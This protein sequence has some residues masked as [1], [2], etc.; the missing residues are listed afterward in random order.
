MKTETRLQQ[1]GQGRFSGV[2]KN[3]S[4]D[5]Y[6]SKDWLSQEWEN[7]WSKTWQIGAH[8]SDLKSPGDFVVLDL[9]PESILIALPETGPIRAFYNVC[10]H[11][12]VRLVEA[13]YGNTE[14]FRCPYH[15]W[16]YSNDGSLIYTPHKEGFQGG[17]PEESICLPEIQCD[18]A[19][20]FV[21]IN[22]DEKAVSLKETLRDVIPLMNHY[23]FGEMTLVQDQTVRINCNWKTVID[24]FAE[25]YHVPFLHPQ[26]RR[27]VDCSNALSEC[28]NGGHTRVC[29]PGATTDSLFSTPRKPSDLHEIQLK[30][31]GLDPTTFENKVDQIQEAI[32]KAKRNLQVQQPYYANFTDEELTDVIQTNIFPNSMLAYQ[33]E[34]LW[35]LRLRPHKN[36]PNQ[37]FFDKLSF[38]RF[39]DSKQQLFLEGTEGV[40]EK[41]TAQQD[42]IGRPQKEIFEYQDVIDGKRSMTDTIDQDLSLLSKAQDGMHSKGFQTTLLNEIECRVSHFHEHLQNLISSDEV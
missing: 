13:S 10:Q 16:R 4:K 11:R 30:A 12:G 42:M 18:E 37:C 15:S 25:L 20:G 17:P 7:V 32:R 33:P 24:N 5:R 38:E 39:P 14:N 23:E 26:H 8:I 35:L 31:L 36:D 34:M 1:Q 28:F 6:I 41:R 2:I 27:F 40:T 22:F 3:F 29:V 19:L 9:G 21:W